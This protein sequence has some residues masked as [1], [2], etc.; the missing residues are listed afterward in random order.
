MFIIFLTNKSLSNERGLMEKEND[1][2]STFLLCDRDL[3]G[4][5][6][7]HFSRWQCF[8]LTVICDKYSTLDPSGTKLKNISICEKRNVSILIRHRGTVWCIYRINDA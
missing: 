7:I 2:I 6:F 3:L 1:P 8:S 4:E 5:I